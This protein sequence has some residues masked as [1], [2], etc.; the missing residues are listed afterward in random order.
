MDKC[1]EVEVNVSVMNVDCCWRELIMSVGVLILI[2]GAKL[3]QLPPTSKVALFADIHGSLVH[4]CM[5]LFYST[6]QHLISIDY[7][8]H[9]PGVSVT[10]ESYSLA[11]STLSNHSRDPLMLAMIVLPS[12]S[13]ET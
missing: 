4:V 8:Q 10:N 2:F 7:E 3:G 9:L 11:S 6:I 1:L 13:P 5:G 12:M